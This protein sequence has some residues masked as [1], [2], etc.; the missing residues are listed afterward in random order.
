M[1]IHGLVVLSNHLHLALSPQSPQQ[2]AAFMEYAAG[3]IAREIGRLHNCRE[4]FWARGY[5]AILVSHEEEAQVGRLAYLICNGVKEGVVERR[6][7]GPACTAL[8]PCAT[9]PSFAAPGAIGLP[10]RSALIRWHLLRTAPH[11]LR[12]ANQIR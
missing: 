7:T 12:R 3:N 10:S 8:E 2:L 5:R 4:K 9:S 6:V 1:R 11:L